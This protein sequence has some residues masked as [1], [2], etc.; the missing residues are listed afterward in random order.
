MS[1]ARL[2]HTRARPQA[3]A[4]ARGAGLHPD[5]AL[6][7]HA[8]EAAVDASSAITA[9]QTVVGHSVDRYTID[10]GG[11]QSSGGSVEIS[12]GFRGDGSPAA[13]SPTRC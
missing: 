2:L 1:A 13:A 8:R 10:N 4:H 12:G 7:A 11:G 3:P 6:P 9:A 5:A